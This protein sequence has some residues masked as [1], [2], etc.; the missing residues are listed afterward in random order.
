VAGPGA[1]TAGVSLT[2]LRYTYY[3]GW[4]PS[5]A[6]AGRLSGPVP[7]GWRLVLVAW[8]DPA[9]HDSTRDHNAGND[10]YFPGDDLTV[11]DQN[12]FA[13]HPYDL[14]YGGYPGITTRIYAVL[15]E[16]PKVAPMLRAAGRLMGLSGSDLDAW[17][18]R[19]LGYAAVPSAPA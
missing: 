18:V 19:E 8:A 7:A 16:A 1:R 4:H 15:V 13:V 11:T 2:E 9:T 5:L 6:L 14:G 3:A 10:L 17:G 12:C